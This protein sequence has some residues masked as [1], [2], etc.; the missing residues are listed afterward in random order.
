MFETILEYV[1]KVMV[2]IITIV[3]SGTLIYYVAS[4]A[5]SKGIEISDSE[6]EAIQNIIMKVVKYF[7][8]TVVYNLKADSEDGKLT[9]EQ[10]AKIRDEAMQMIIMILGDNRI[11]SLIGKYGN[12]YAEVVEYLHVLLENA[13]LD[14]KESS[15]IIA[16]ELHTY[17][18]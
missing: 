11:K 18:E 9:D 16:E 17:F 10:A 15:P 2:P 4:V 6:M 12:T 5:K 7:N 8:Q 13:V 1:T 3:A 14:A